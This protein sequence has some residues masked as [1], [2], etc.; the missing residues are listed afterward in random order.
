M[1]RGQV[2]SW[3]RATARGR[4]PAL[5]GDLVMIAALVLPG[6]TWWSSIDAPARYLA[7]GVPPGQLLYV[8]AKLA[9]LYAMA[10]L[11]LQVLYG[12]LRETAWAVPA[13]R[14]TVAAHRNLGIT[15]AMLAVLHAGLFITGV[16]MRAGHFAAGLLV[17]NFG[18]AYY[19]STVSLGVTAAWLLIAVILAAALRRREGL[20]W[21]WV[22]RLGLPALALVFFHSLLVGSESRLGAMPYLY[23]IMGVVF[24]AALIYRFGPRRRPALVLTE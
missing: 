14:W 9:G 21:V 1:R 7:A 2:V 12:L 16:S 11:W 22:H 18:G 5:L 6:V 3:G 23:G 8:L 20:Q 10:L 24:C 4:A 19:A 15:V 17:P 13:R